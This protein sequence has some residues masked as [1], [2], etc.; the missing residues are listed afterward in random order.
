MSKLAGALLFAAVAIAFS[1]SHA[2]P[3]DSPTVQDVVPEM[4]VYTS[5]ASATTQL[6]TAERSAATQLATDEFVTIE[7]NGI[8][9]KKRSRRRKKKR[10]RRKARS[11]QPSSQPSS[12]PSSQPSSEP[13]SSPTQ[14]D[15]ERWLS[16]YWRPGYNC[17]DE[18]QPCDC[19]ENSA[20][21]YCPGE[22]PGQWP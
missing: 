21:V 13:S 11:S 6:R 10:S 15:V 9:K 7:G 22:G 5:K 4:E 18:C 19:Y 14:W 17:R 12:E 16:Q 2:S 3:L 20:W 1:T 8:G